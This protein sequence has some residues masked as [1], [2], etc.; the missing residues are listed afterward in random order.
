MKKQRTR[1]RKSVPDSKK[2]LISCP[3]SVLFFYLD[4]GLR[5]E[6]SGA[7]SWRGEIE[8]KAP[9]EATPMV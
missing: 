2:Q 5:K 6:E 1:V 8:R 4:L 9:M 7:G 3:T